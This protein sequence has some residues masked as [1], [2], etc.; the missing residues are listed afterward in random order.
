MADIGTGSGA[1]ALSLAFE[2]EFDLVIATDISLESAA[3]ARLTPIVQ[4]VK[5]GRSVEIRPGDFLAPLTAEDQVDA[6]VCKPAL[7]RF[8]EIAELPAD[9][10]DW[11]P[12]LALLSADDGLACTQADPPGGGGARAGGLLALE[13]DTRRAERVA[14]YARQNGAYHESRFSAISPAASGSCSPITEGKQMLDEKAKELGRI[15]GQ[16][17]EYQARQA[18]ERSAPQDREA[19]R[20]SRAWRSCARTRSGC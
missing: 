17:P 16:S 7:H 20:R 9:V 4:K 10:R 19:V 15:I 1:I 5:C 18:L 14:E 2:R 3:V 6:I 11:E 12:H 8:A 13:C